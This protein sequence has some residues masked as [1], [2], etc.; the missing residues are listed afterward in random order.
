[1]DLL[2]D[3]GK[4]PNVANIGGLL[5]CAVQDADTGDVIL[6]GCRQDLLLP[7]PKLCHWTTGE[8]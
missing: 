1:M 5:P 8:R 7:P 2:L 6:T 4:L 3:F